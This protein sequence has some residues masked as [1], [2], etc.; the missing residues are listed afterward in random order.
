MQG[1]V[2][3]AGGRRV[4]R[5]CLRAG[6]LGAALLA[7]RTGIAAEKLRLCADPQ[8]LPFSS[9]DASHPGLYVEIGQAVAAALG[10]EAELSWSISNFG[11]R[12][13]RETLLAGQCD[14]AI[15]LPDDKGFMGPRVI[16]SRPILALGYALLLPAGIQVR[17]LGDLAGLK[18]AVQLASPP[19]SL[20]ATREDITSVTVLSPEEGVR[21]MTSGKADLAFIWGPTAGWM[22]AS[23]LHGGYRVIPVA[24]PGMQWHAAIGFARKQAQLR[25]AVDGVLPGILPQIPGLAAKYGLPADEPMQ[26]SAA[27]APRHILLVDDTQP[28]QPMAQSD[29][30]A[31]PGPADAVAPP[32]GAAAASTATELVG[33]GHEIF[34][35][36]CAHCHGPDAVVS[37]R[38]INLRLLHHRYGDQM[39]EVFHT[40]VTH[41]R[42][43]KGMPNWS[44]VFSEDDFS[45]IFAWL[46]TVQQD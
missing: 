16:Y 42:P 38:R 18:V 4:L 37:E 25:D 41:G 40:T 13:L 43:S 34:N 2:S 31:Q 10:R 28:S 11:K 6:L 39:E 3:H 21:A 24:G 12:N 46:K 26:L 45:K 19:Q 9:K 1:N 30:A 17:G 33:A 27:G 5:A 14:V 29:T 23:E 32:P 7:A 15:G 44:G 35:G 22:N 36:T 20:L 8:D